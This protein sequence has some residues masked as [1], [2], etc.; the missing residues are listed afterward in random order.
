MTARNAPEPV[1]FSNVVAYKQ[2]MPKVKQSE[3]FSSWLRD[4]RD[5]KARAKIAVR[6]QRLEDGNPGDVAPVGDGVSEMRIH[7]GPG[8]RVYFAAR[9]AELVILLCGGDK[10]SQARD[11]ETAKRLAQTEE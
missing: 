10:A 1:A 3:T 8:Y 7:Y 5:T 9:G 6:I 2:Q 11:I 4:L